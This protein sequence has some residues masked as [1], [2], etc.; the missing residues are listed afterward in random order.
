MPTPSMYASSTVEAHASNALSHTA[1]G[2]C[3][4]GFGWMQTHWAVRASA[5]HWSA[6]RLLGATARA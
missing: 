4:S 1:C 6:R 5:A 3:L 2:L